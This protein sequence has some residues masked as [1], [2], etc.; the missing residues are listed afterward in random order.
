MRSEG[1]PTAHQGSAERNAVLRG[2]SADGSL[3][4]AD[5]LPGEVE[6][7]NAEWVAVFSRTDELEGSDRH[8]PLVVYRVVSEAPNS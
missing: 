7:E 4:Q 8:G 1:R 6:I 2:G 3:V 5:G